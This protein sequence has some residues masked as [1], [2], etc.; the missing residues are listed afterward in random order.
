MTLIVPEDLTAKLEALAEHQNRTPEE[1][2][3]DLIE[4]EPTPPKQP[5]GKRVAG[6]GRGTIWVSDDFDDYLGDD[7]WFGEE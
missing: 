4:K 7:F 1:V 2:L 6:L 5:D 3:R